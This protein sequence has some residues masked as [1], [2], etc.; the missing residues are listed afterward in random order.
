MEDIARRLAARDWPNITDKLHDKGFVI[1][2]GVLTEKEC[3][4]VRNGV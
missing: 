3:D 2:K 1:V 4:T